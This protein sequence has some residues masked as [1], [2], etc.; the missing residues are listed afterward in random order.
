MKKLILTS[1]FAIIFGGCDDFGNTNVDPNNPEDPKTDLLLTEAQRSIG[2]Y[3]GSVTGTLYVQYFAET[4]YTDESTYTS[5]DF[6]FDSGYNGNVYTEPLHNLETI[7]ELNSDEEYE[8]DPNVVDAGSQNNQIAVA[9]ILKAYFFQSLVDRW[10]Y[11]PYSDALEDD[12][13][14]S[15]SYD[16]PEEIYED[17]LTELEEAVAQID[18]G[19]GPTGD[20]V[21][22]GNMVRWEEFANTLRMRIALRIADERPNLAQEAYE[23]AYDS[24]HIQ[25]DITFPY[26]EDANNENPWFN[27]FRTRTDYA[28]SNTVA[29]TM[30][31]LDDYRLT[32]FAD[33]APNYEDDN[34]DEVA[35]DEINPMPYGVSS[36]EAGGITNAEVS[37]PGQAIRQ[38][39][40]ALPVFTMAEVH[41]SLA[42]ASERGWDVAGDAQT[43]Y[44]EGIQASWEQWGVYDEDD[45]NAYMNET[46]VAYDSN[47]WDA[48]IGFQKWIALFPQGYEAWAEWRRLDYPELEPAPAAVNESSEIPVRQAY[49]TSEAE[50]NGENYEAAVEAQGEDGLDTHLW[51]DGG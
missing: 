16:S 44:E 5:I 41:F 27:R 26:I 43:H 46:A 13:T 19:D 10:G 3:V 6:G 20:F 25:E 35:M 17:L 51:W 32:V 49:P 31:A 15:P 11:V 28:I 38:Q 40:A 21:L 8:D 24:G 1:V 4:Q 30:H 50:L 36:G 34:E 29:D 12:E 9:R 47:E 14:L 48:K 33:P 18:D 42:E 45:F 22:E 39:D 37:F 2:S 7:I 23:D